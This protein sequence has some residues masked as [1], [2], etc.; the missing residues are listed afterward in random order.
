MR[1][2]RNDSITW[3]GSRAHRSVIAAAV[4]RLD[5]WSSSP[6][7]RQSRPPVAG[8][9][10]SADVTKSYP[11]CERCHRHEVAA[12]AA[13]PVRKAGPKRRAHRLAS[14]APFMPESVVMVSKVVA[15]RATPK[16][17]AIEPCVSRYRPG[18]APACFLER[19][20]ATRSPFS[21]LRFSIRISAISECA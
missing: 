18:R 9:V 5:C 6:A 4:E 19:C 11:L 13:G 16:A 14:P 1:A 2:R 10:A 15:K 20:G 7:A 3:P 12:V 8:V 17:C 21:R